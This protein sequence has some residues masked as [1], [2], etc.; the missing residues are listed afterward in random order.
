ME[1]LSDVN[2]WFTGGEEDSL[3]AYFARYFSRRGYEAT[4]KAAEDPR[5]FID[6]LRRTRG[7]E[8]RPH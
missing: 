3:A 6:T 4:A 1:A 2:E 7:E 8:E 5:G